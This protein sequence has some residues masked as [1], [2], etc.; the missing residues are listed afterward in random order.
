[1]TLEMV[2]VSPGLLA[3]YQVE[4]FSFVALCSIFRGALNLARF[5]CHDLPAVDLTNLRRALLAFRDHWAIGGTLSPDNTP[6]EADIFT[7]RSFH[8][9]ART[10]PIHDF[11]PAQG[12]R[13]YGGVIPSSCV[14]VPVSMNGRADQACLVCFC[15]CDWRCCLI[16][17]WLGRAMGTRPRW[18][19]YLG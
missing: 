10:D 3:E 9:R 15:H 7:G 5:F 17:Y 18:Y 1:M 11:E 16:G 8:G 12:L 6:C 13:I 2:R 4:R 14:G 19:G